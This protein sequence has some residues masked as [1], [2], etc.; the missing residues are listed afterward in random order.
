MK[1]WNKILISLT[2][3]HSLSACSAPNKEQTGITEVDYNNPKTVCIGRLEVTVPKE[4]E[5]TY[6]SFN[7]NGSDFEIDNSIKTYED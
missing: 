5:V 1:R 7:F 3:L 4:T 2:F 6:S